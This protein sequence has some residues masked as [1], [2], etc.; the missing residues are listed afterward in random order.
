MRAE[1]ATIFSSHFGFAQDDPA[2]ASITAGDLENF[3]DT[4][5]TPALTGTSWSGVIS[6]AGAGSTAR[7]GTLETVSLGPT[8]DAAPFKNAFVTALITAELTAAPLSAEAFEA[9]ISYGL[10]GASSASADAA[11]LQG[12]TAITEA[13]VEQASERLLAHAGVLNESSEA[14]V[15]TDAF[16]AAARFNDL[17]VKLEA[18]YTM[19]GRLQQ[20]TLLRFLP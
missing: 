4:V 9:A 7:I 14:M 10:S 8:A 16:A 20:L 6:Q 1:F 19:T 5:A 2:A 17:A 13:R 3:I 11:Q 12:S 15:A 18:A